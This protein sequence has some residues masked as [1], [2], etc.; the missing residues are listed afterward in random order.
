M[1]E[2]IQ[3]LEKESEIYSGAYNDFCGFMM[4]FETMCL[5]IEKNKLKKQDREE[6]LDFLNLINQIYEATK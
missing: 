4:I 1:K 2:T 5:K 3:Q 6:L